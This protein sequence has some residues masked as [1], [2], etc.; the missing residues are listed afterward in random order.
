[1]RFPTRDLG[2]GEHAGLRWGGES[3]SWDIRWWWQWGEGTKAAELWAP[4]LLS[5]ITALRGAILSSSSFL[6]SLVSFQGVFVRTVRRR[7]IKKACCP[8]LSDQGLRDWLV[9]L[10]ARTWALE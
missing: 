10:M 2:P 4:E 8:W 9:P 1:M 6:S 3:V 7:G 5:I